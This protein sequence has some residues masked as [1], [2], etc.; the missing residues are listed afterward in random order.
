MEGA[1]GYLLCDDSV[2]PMYDH[3]VGC[4]FVDDEPGAREADEPVEY[5]D[6][7]VGGDEEG[8]AGE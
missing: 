5:F 3:D 6:C 1:K 4:C 2:M 7:V 8:D